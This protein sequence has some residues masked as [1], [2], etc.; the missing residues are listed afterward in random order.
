M[1]TP[2]YF[3]HVTKSNM[4]EY[5]FKMSLQDIEPML[6]GSFLTR[7]AIQHH[8]K[9]MKGQREK[10][11]CVKR[12]VTILLKHFLQCATNGEFYTI[13]CPD[14]PISLDDG[15][16]KISFTK[17]EIDDMI[18]VFNFERRGIKVSCSDDYNCGT[19]S[20]NF[21]WSTQ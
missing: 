10:L 18:D 1:T 20:Y 21:L 19:I 2:W 8:E 7:V 11:E 14:I 4:S 16:S 3:Y 9:I 12:C 17:K 15:L 6:T 5:E 13:I